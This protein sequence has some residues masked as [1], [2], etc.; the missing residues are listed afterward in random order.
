MISE[1]FLKFKVQSSI[2]FSSRLSQIHR[3]IHL[4]WNAKLSQVT[5]FER[6]RIYGNADHGYQCASVA[7]STG[8]DN[9][10]ENPSVIESGMRIITASSLPDRGGTTRVY[11]Y[12]IAYVVMLLLTF[13]TDQI[14]G[15][16]II[17][18]NLFHIGQTE[19]VPNTIQTES[20]FT[21]CQ[22]HNGRN[23]I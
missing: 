11:G 22:V 21:N 9:R 8:Y 12:R 14:T 17:K 20:S 18:P 1:L 10:V 16:L 4:T 23:I 5:S 13:P 15:T 3:E 19:L 7:V 6:F 2:P